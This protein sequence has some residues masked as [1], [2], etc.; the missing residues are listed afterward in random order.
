MTGSSK[1]K[2]LHITAIDF[3][4]RKML[5]DKLIELQ[6]YG[7]DV[8]TMSDVTG[9]MSEAKSEMSGIQSRGIKHHRIPISRDIHPVKDIRSI[10]LLYRFLKINKYDIVHTHTAKA[11]FIGR[12]AA[13]L[14]KV[15][16]IIHTSHGLPFYKG[17]SVLKNGI[18]RFLETFA[19]YF[20]H[21]YLSQ[22]KEDLTN[23]YRMVP[24]KIISGYEGNGIP[25]DV[26][27]GYEKMTSEEIKKKKR[28]L[29]IGERDFVFFTAARFEA[30]KNYEMIFNAIRKVSGLK[31]NVKFVFAG[32]GPL[33]EEYKEKA[34]RWKISNDIIFL[35]YRE[36]MYE[37]L[38]MTDAVLL[39]SE[40]EGIPRF[41][42]EA[43]A[44][45]KPVLATDVLGTNELVVN[46]K[47]GELIEFNNHYQL[48]NTIHNWINPEYKSVLY[49]Y[50][51]N[52]RKRIVEEF[53]EAKVAKRIHR[54][55]QH[56]LSRNGV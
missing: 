12:I 16:I 54:Y 34:V 2:V 49:L 39:T 31:Q 38:Q 19:S 46:Q 8:E 27:D 43:M 52:G 18:Y 25:L 33:L 30:V 4:I 17:Q 44:F 36:D 26:L 13:K 23:I 21:A 3:T 48:A 42:M 40:K 9:F 10:F 35:G 53:T 47:T 24:K 37:L 1:V 41:L 50:G 15:P 6:K 20:S 5:V 7:Y 28:S 45:E 11:G 56:L 55:Y 14:A 32:E 29:E 51:K 22:N